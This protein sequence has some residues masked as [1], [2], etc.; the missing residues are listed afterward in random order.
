MQ[1]NPQGDI[2]HRL[3]DIPADQDSLEQVARFCHGYEINLSTENAVRVAC[4][5]D[6][7]GMT[8]THCSNNLLNKT[9]L[10]M[11]ENIFPS[12]SNSIKAL[13]TAE[14]VFEQAVKLGLV[15]YCVESIILKTLKNP[16]LLGEPI[17]NAAS[18]S[19]SDDDDDDYENRYKVNAR[20]KLFDL[21]WKSEDLTS[22][23]LRVYAH[24]IHSMINRGVPHAYVAANLCEYTNA[25]VF[26]CDKIGDEMSISMR[27]HYKEMVETLVGLT[28]NLVGFLP[29]KFLCEVLRFAIA[30]HAN[31]ECRNALELKIG[32]KLHQATVKDLLIP[33]EGYAKDEKYDTE[34]LKRIL[35]NFCNYGNPDNRGLNSVAQVMDEFLAEISADIDLKTTTFLAVA[36]MSTALSQGI[37]RSSD[38]V[39]RA[40]DIYLDKHRHLTESEKEKLCNILDCSRLSPE[41]SEHA[42][43][44]GLLPLR[45]VVQVLFASHLKLRDAIPG[46]MESKV[47]ELERECHVMR[48]EI[49]S[50]GG[51]VRRRK[52]S[53]WG[54]MKRKFGCMPTVHDC[55]CHKK[56]KR[57]CTLNRAYD[58]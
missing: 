6:Y 28:D 13:K 58:C 15:E 51:C 29:C 8:E 21:E 18:S 31:S 5:A 20:R 1:E 19:S 50:G 32:M 10:F 24:I 43:Q 23:S 56:R 4:L 40:V 2:S 45:V 41:A 39:Y 7:L 14:N 35:M 42:A 3:R 22:L 11:E 33:C 57:S 49:E 26:S 36:D 30:V 27:N 9:L 34:S 25:W 17:K 37:Q 47:N 16:R 46:E 38:G 44:N 52:S 53:V 48:R 12:W 55:N 54:K